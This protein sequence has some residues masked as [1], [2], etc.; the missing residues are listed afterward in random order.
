MVEMNKKFLNPKLSAIEELNMR[1]VK[2]F[3]EKFV[4]FAAVGHDMVAEFVAQNCK[5]LPE[6]IVPAVIQGWHVKI[7]DSSKLILEPL[8]EETVTS[9]NCQAN[10]HFL[11]LLYWMPVSQINAIFRHKYMHHRAANDHDP[12]LLHVSEYQGYPILAISWIKFN[13]KESMKVKESLHR[14]FL[15]RGLIQRE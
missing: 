7:V 15:L 13:Q 10:Q 5:V 1:Y 9:Q 3:S 8:A 2:Q 4:W 6:K 12:E 14:Y 11:T